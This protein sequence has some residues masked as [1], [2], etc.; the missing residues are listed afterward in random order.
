VR[1][2]IQNS[3]VELPSESWDLYYAVSGFQDT[4]EWIAFSVRKETLWTTIQRL[5][6][7]GQGDFSN[8]LSDD[9][10]PPAPSTEKY[11]KELRSWRVNEIQDPLYLEDST[12]RSSGRTW[13]LDQKT[14][15]IYVYRWTT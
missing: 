9:A 8:E 5:T 3:G 14:G 6:G 10:K 11:A 15:R 12:N 4:E 13:I 2:A 1:D 7:R